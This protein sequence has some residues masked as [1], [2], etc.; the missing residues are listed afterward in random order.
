MIEVPKPRDGCPWAFYEPSTPFRFAVLILHTSTNQIPDLAAE[1]HRHN[2]AAC[3]PSA[4]DGW[5]VKDAEK[6]VVESVL[7]WMR[8]RWKLGPRSIAVV[9][10]E[11][12]GQGAVRLGFKY[13]DSFPVV[14]SLDGAFDFHDLYGE[15]TPLDGLYPSRERA[16]QDTAILNIDPYKVPPHIWFACDPE[17]EWFRGND[18]LVEKLN[19][20][21]IAHTADLAG[22]KPGAMIEFA[23]KALHS[24]SRKLM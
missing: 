17:S 6:H 8:E 21:G 20:Y 14:A 7:P 2:L 13:P 19:A 22:A 18:R 10:V 24:V 16:R 11:A 1:L 4:P 23:A 5:W 9:G 3:V 15:G 12:G